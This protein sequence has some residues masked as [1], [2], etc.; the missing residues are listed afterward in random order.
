[1]GG[2]LVAQSSKVSELKTLIEPS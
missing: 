1:L 2:S